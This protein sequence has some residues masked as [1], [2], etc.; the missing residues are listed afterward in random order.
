MRILS[1]ETTTNFGSIANLEDENIKNEI[2]FESLDI[3]GELVRKLDFV[4]DEFDYIVVSTGPGSWTGIRIGISFAKGLA[5]GKRDKIYSVNVFEG[6]FHTVKN[7]KGKFLCVVPFTKDKFYY[8][9]FSG[10]FKYENMFEINI[11][12]YD[13]ILSIIKKNEYVLIGPGV[14]SLKNFIE[15]KKFKTINFLWYPRASFNALVAYEKIKRNIPSSL[16]EPIYG[17]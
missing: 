7:I 1:I 6:L 14:L 3:A 10:D 9:I 15:I 12:T 5:V 17:K 16:P 2:F 13:K 8:S 4:Y 11:T